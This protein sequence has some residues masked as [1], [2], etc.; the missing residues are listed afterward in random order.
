MN[1]DSLI[2]RTITIVMITIMTTN[3]KKTRKRELIDT[4]SKTIKAELSKLVRIVV[5][6][7]TPACFSFAFERTFF[8]EFKI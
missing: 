8:D 2:T 4:F 1:R 7:D 5:T 6:S 3:T